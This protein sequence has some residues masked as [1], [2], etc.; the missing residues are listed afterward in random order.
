MAKRLEGK[1]GEV[2]QRLWGDVEG[3]EPGYF[4]RISGSHTGGFEEY[5]LLGYDAV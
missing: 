2:Q 5:Y 3:I 1:Y 4:F